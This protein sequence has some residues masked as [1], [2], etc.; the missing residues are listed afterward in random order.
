VSLSLRPGRFCVLALGIVM[1][2][3]IPA[4]TAAACP[5]ADAGASAR[6]YVGAVECLLNEQRAGA[7]LAPLTDDRH[8]ARAARRFSG[9]MVRERFFDH[10][11]PEGS[12]VTDR[13]RQAGFPGRT[14]G[15]TI[16]W[17]SYEYSTPEAIVQGWMDSPGH[18]EIIMDGRF[19][20]VGLGVALGAPSNGVDG[21]R[22][23]TADFGT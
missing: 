9:A 4:A 19:R 7:G 2:V 21:A 18:R 10:V 17:G 22:T 16:A 15:E 11:S 14:L 1:L 20:R 23:V 12:T 3:L 5:A 8:L 13:V 6:A